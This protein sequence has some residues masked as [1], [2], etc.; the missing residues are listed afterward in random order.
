MTIAEHLDHAGPEGARAWLAAARGRISEDP[1]SISVLFPA[2][3]RTCGR[4]Q[5][6]GGARV[7]DAVRTLL[8]T[9]LPLTGADLAGRLTQLYR[10]GD[11]DEKRAVIRALD[12]LDDAPREL[13]DRALPLIVDALRTND[14]RLVG[15]ALG[16]YAARRLDA[17]S[18]RHAVLK[19][20]FCQ[21]P[22]VQAVGLD[23]RADG[24]LA[25]MLADFASERTTAGRTVPPDVW[26]LLARF[27]DALAHFHDAGRP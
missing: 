3:G 10:H 15:V 16:E 20:V 14:T 18:Y 4:R 9:W 27:P 5:L 21:I 19:F 8:L 2:V 25:R 6:P 7:D 22:L 12:A 13:G 26:P 17:A 24:E 23:R 1:R 11:N